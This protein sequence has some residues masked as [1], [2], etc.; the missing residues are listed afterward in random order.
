MNNPRYDKLYYEIYALLSME[1]THKN[2]GLN[3][4]KGESPDWQNQID[5]IGLEIARAENKHI[6]YT[7]NLINTYLGKNKA[8]IPEKIIKKFDGSLSFRNEHLLTVSDSKNLV[9]GTRHIDFAIDTLKAKTDLL[10]QQHFLVFKRNFLFLYLINT[11][12]DTD[13]DLFCHK[14]R[15]VCSDYNFNFDKVILLDY[16][17]LHIIDLAN[18]KT[19]AIE[20]PDSAFS[21]LRHLSQELYGLSSWTDGTSFAAVYQKSC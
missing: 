18:R 15:Q 7:K 1:Y 10:N 20:M 12:S 19:K 8:E 11:A 6:G 14:S 16:T 21:V 5:E 9:E 13:I 17:C 2:F 4:H 3:F